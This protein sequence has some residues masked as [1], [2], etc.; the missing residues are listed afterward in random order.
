[1]PQGSAEFRGIKIATNT[2]FVI[3]DITSAYSDIPIIELKLNVENF[4]ETYCSVEKEQMDLMDVYNI[5][6]TKTVSHIIIHFFNK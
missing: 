6:I 5:I 4:L 2:R 1:L 3:F